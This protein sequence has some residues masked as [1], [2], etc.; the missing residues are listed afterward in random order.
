MTRSRSRGQSRR[1]FFAIAAILIGGAALFC[2]IAGAWPFAGAG[3]DENDKDTRTEI[4]FWGHPQIGDEIYTLLHAFERKNPQ[5]KVTMGSAVALDI[6]GDSQRLLCTIA[7]GVPPD[8]VWFDRFAIGEWAG[9]DALTDLTPLL[10]AQKKDDPYRIDTSQYFS[11]SIEEASYRAPGAGAQT[12]S[13]VFGIPSEADVR[14]FYANANLL[15]Q[16][17]LVDPKSGEPVL[18]KNWD[19]LSDY[20]KRLTRYKVANDPSSGIERLGFAPNVGN[21]WLYLY[22]WQ[23][24]GEFL[25]STRTKCT[26]DAPE[27]VRALAWMSKLYD[28]LGGYGQVESLKQSFGGGA[29]DPFIQNTIA[30]KIDNDRF[31]RFIADW[32]PDMDFIVAPPP[33][34]QDQIDAGHGPIS[35]SGGFAYVI[36]RT[37]TQKE[38]AWRLIQYLASWEAVQLLEQG[39]REL[40]QSEGK[41]YLPEG[42]ANRVFYERLVDEH[43]LNNPQVPIR[44]REAYQV[45]RKLMPK[46][47]IRPVSP[48]GQLLWNQHVRAMDAACNHAYADEAKRTGGSEAQIALREMKGDVQRQLD[49]LL[50]PPP[51]HKVKWAGYFYAYAAVV[52]APFALML[53]VYRKRRKEYSYRSREVGSALFFASPWI[54]G[55]IVFVAGPILF[56]IVFSFTRYDVL[57]PARYVGLANYSELFANKTFYKSV[58]NTIYMLARVPLAMAVSLAVALLLNCTM[59]GIGAYRTGFYLPAIMPLVA[60][61]LLW[62]WVFNGN[63]GVLNSILSW[64]FSTAPFEWIAH[65]ISHFTAQPFRFTPPLWLQDKNWSKPALIIM[66]VWTAGGAMIIWLAGLQSI[67]PTLYEAASVDGAGPWRR[68]WHVTVPMLSPYILFNAIIG[69]I[70][71]MKMFEE[72]FI[73]TPQAQPVDSTL[74]YAYNLFKQAFQFFR[75]GYASA[76]AW[77]LFL[78]VLGLTALQLHFSKRWVHY[79]RT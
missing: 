30:M 75:M 76:L 40:K 4:V 61:S 38:G 13:K 47:R 1:I 42:S 24:G 15:R 46:T 8:V 19:Q 11:W 72:A 44:F 29:V 5:Y 66:Y 63:Y 51:P 32:R 73:M 33:M 59:R 39:K 77:I 12:A 79:D 65:A 2:W 57:S 43:V 31:L 64:L 55:L 3:T 62:Q 9:R 6:T 78:I 52:A 56:S 23:A 41:L 71:T 25:D 67:P 36:P 45:T 69:V 26:L 21:S 49:E 28:E 18:P 50:A 54:V 70:A 34:P 14:I 27:N 60:A 48:V 74:F 53:F 68:F 16:A 35:W 37:A 58:A 7:G 20:A 17:N 22:A 10:A